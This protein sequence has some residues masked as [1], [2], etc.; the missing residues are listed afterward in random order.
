VTGTLLNVTIA[1]R[2]DQLDALKAFGER[3]GIRR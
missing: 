1:F 2:R 3:A